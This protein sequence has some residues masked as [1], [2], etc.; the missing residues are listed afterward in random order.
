MA[1]A[2]YPHVRVRGGAFARGVQY[3]QRAGE[4]VRRS[5]QAYE[6]LFGL[7]AG[8]EWTAVVEL[9]ARF[10]P[11]IEAYD[12]SYLE[13]MRGIARGAEVAFEDIVALNVRTEVMFS[14]KARAAQALRTAPRE[15]TALVALPEAT[16]SGHTL[17]A[18]NWDWMVHARDTL[19]VLEAEQD[20]GPRFVTLVEAGLLAKFGM[21]E[22]GLAVLTNA[23]VSALDRGEP[24]VPYHVLLRSLHDATSMSDA[25]TRLQSQR[26]SSSANYL[27]AHKDGL[28]IDA[29][30]MPGDFAQLHLVQPR[31]GLLAHTNHFI[32]ERFPGPDVGLWVMPDSP[33]RLQSVL[34]FV[35]RRRGR[36]DVASVE[37][38]LSL[39]QGHPSGVCSHADEECD[40]AEQ[41]ATIASAV[42]DLDELRMWIADGNPCATG[43]RAMDYAGF[44]GGDRRRPTARP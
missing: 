23:L 22:A 30:A 39:H 34:G 17:A 24:G 3:G 7:W 25:L 6:R 16:R 40:A 20:G 18:Q 10:V 31:R 19:V 8:L 36:L 27:L 38:A 15:C 43:Y 14:A 2:H 41:E 13:E 26:R 33:L 44:L 29:E 37:E 32:S 12:G 5:I 28:G 35:R 42:M 21:N 1:E 9:A 4:R 11:A